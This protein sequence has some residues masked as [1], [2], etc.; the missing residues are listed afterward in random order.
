MT[1]SELDI[2]LLPEVRQAIEQNLGRDPLSVA[3]DKSVPYAREV[4]T[5]LKYL[6]R[7]RHKLPTLYAARCIIPGRAFEQSSSEE[8]AAA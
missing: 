7:A 4:A 5:Q 2:L 1:R 8:S 3:L 6:E